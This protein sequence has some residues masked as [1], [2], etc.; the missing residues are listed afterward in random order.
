MSKLRTFAFRAGLRF[1]PIFLIGT[2]IARAQAPAPPSEGPPPII[3]TTRSIDTSPAR[4]LTSPIAVKAVVRVEGTPSPGLRMTLNGSGSSGGRLWY[5]W[6]QTQG[7]RVK[8]EDADRAEAHFLVPL[9]ASFLAFVLVVGEASGIDVAPVAIEVEGPERD[10]ES[11]ALRADAGDDQS[12]VVGRRILLNGMRSEPKGQI[13]FRWIQSGGPSIELPT[14]DAPTSSFVP[15]VPGTYQFAL[16]V[17]TP[18]GL[19]SEPSAVK[20]QVKEPVG[21]RTG[22]AGEIPM[23]IDEL[24][25]SAIDSIE[26]GERY[27]EGLSDA[28]DLVAN[29][30]ESLPTY[31]DASAELTRRLESLVP[32][33]RER[34]SVWT[35]QFFSPLMVRLVSEMKSEELDLNQPEAIARP[36]TRPQRARLA[37]QFRM[38]AA[39]LRASTM[40]R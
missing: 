15:T 19:M 29:R 40:L 3:A 38:T 1:A 2:S 26:G 31:H 35:E 32:S 6:L 22:T 13:R 30:L 27:A 28:F 9:D 34:R 18:D 7:P 37:E 33:D 39:G 11:L 14:G 20:V 10:G 8:I 25:R 21:S 23:A 16:I 12:S 5:R 24:A 4:S 36:M 17:A